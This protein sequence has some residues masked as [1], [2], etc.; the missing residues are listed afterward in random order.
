MGDLWDRNIIV[1]PNQHPF[2]LYLLDWELARTGLP[3]TDIGTFCASMDILIHGNQF[4]S[5]PASVILQNFLDAYSRISNRDARLAQDTLVHWGAI[6]VFWG[7]RDPPGGRK[8]AHDLV[9]KGVKFWVDSRD[10]DF[11]EQSPVKGLLPR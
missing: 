2:R 10:Q 3:G 9:R 7:P 4:A 6:H 11:Q 1:N 5:G 8:L